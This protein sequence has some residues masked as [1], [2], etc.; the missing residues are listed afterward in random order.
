[1]RVVLLPHGIED[2]IE[3]EKKPKHYR[4]D[5]NADQRL[6]FGCS[7]REHPFLLFL[8]SEDAESH[9]P[10]NDPRQSEQRSEDKT[11]KKGGLSR[12]PRKPAVQSIQFIF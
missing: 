10:Q 1:M 6:I 8:R 11:K 4:R 5:N 12:L 9:D 7:G 2:E 3:K